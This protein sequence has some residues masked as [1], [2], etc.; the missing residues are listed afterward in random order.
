MSQKYLLDNFKKS[1]KLLI[2][3][4]RKLGFLNHLRF[5]NKIIKIISLTKETTAKWE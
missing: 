4:A 3:T 2:T 1:K 5:T